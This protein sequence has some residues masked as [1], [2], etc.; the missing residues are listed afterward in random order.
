[1]SL[2]K[3]NSLVKEIKKVNRINTNGWKEFK[4]GGL[5]DCDTAKQI[6]KVEGGNF[7]QVNRSAFNNGITKYV[8]KIENKINKKN[9]ITIGAEGFFAFYQEEDFMAGN[10]IYVIR[11]EKLNKL[12]GLFVCSVLNS[13]I[14]RY[15]YNNARIL[16]KIKEESHKFPVDNDGEPDWKYMEEYVIE[17]RE[18][19]E[20][21]LK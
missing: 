2:S 21:I 5:F 6:L 7:P 18:K 1:M 20:K 13:I 12:N 3:I 19:I 15:S 16:K 17:L 11:H 8:K 4:I 10:K 9:C 14:P